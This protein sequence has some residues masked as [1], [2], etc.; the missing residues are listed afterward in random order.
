MTAFKLYCLRLVLRAQLGA[1]D[2]NEAVAM[3]GLQ[4]LHRSLEAG[5]EVGQ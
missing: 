5:E 1:E 3:A 2:D 4:H